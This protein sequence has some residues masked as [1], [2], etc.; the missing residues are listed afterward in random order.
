MHDLKTS[1]WEARSSSYPDFKRLLA[2]LSKEINKHQPGPPDPAETESQHELPETTARKRRRVEES[3]VHDERA[4]DQDLAW[5]PG[6]STTTGAV[7]ERDAAKQI[8]FLETPI[9]SLDQSSNV[10]DFTLFEIPDPESMFDNADLPAIQFG[11]TTNIEEFAL[12][13]VPEHLSIPPDPGSCTFPESVP[14]SLQS[15]DDQ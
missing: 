2:E 8:S 13:F 11:H 12:S 1:T 10:E 9:S 3:A 15:G 7:H 4:G 5:T 6:T 14:S